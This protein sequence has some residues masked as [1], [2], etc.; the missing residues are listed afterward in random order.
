V[1]YSNGHFGFSVQ[2]RIYVECGA[3]L[4]GNYPGNEVWEKFG[5]RVGW[6]KDGDWLLYSDFDP[7]FS[8][9]H[10]IFPVFLWWCL[11]VELTGWW[12]SLLSH[13]DL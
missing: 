7:S 8:S 1:S 11:G 10:G 4:D 12:F 2:K 6:R 9:P 3:T 13:P 5:D